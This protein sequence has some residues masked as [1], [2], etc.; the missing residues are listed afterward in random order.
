M[1]HSA[2]YTAA[3]AA[4]VLREPRSKHCTTRHASTVFYNSQ[5]G[6]PIKFVRFTILVKGDPDGACWRALFPR[7]LCS[8]TRAH[9]M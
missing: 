4:F 7:H 1:A 6:V 5:C 3:E 2:Q 9:G 8:S